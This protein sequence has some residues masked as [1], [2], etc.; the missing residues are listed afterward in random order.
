[1]GKEQ[2]QHHRQDEGHADKARQLAEHEAHRSAEKPGA[3]E[4]NAAAEECGNGIGDF[5]PSG[6]QVKIEGAVQDEEQGKVHAAGN[7]A[8]QAD[9]RS[10][11]HTLPQKQQGNGVHAVREQTGEHLE[12]PGAQHAVI[13]SK[14][15][16]HEEKANQHRHRHEQAGQDTVNG[17]LGV[18]KGRFLHRLP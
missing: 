8:L 18:V 3:R 7:S 11:A 13:F 6:R 15:I 9:V 17:S 1:M 2:K 14:R 12:K 10:P 5:L 16:Q 4:G